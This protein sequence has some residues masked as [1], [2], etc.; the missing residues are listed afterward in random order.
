MGDIVTKVTE[1]VNN[2]SYYVWNDA[3]CHSHCDACPCGCDVTTHPIS[4]KNGVT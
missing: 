1:A 3:E 2:C 4:L